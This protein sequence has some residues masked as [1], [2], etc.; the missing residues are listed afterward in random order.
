MTFPFFSENRWMDTCQ[1]D[2][3]ES[4]EKKATFRLEFDDAVTEIIKVRIEWKS[5]PIFTNT[6]PSPWGGETNEHVF[7]N[8]F[9]DQ[10]PSD[11]TMEL[12]GV[13]V[14][15]EYGGPWNTGGGN[16]QVTVEADITQKV[17]DAGIYD[18]HTIEIRTAEPASPRA[19]NFPSQSSHTA[20][21]SH[22]WIEMR[23]HIL[24]VAQAIVP[25]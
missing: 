7:Y 2:S 11:L 23:I 12:N 22:G 1:N 18:V 19:I 15:S 14:S 17:L 21:I 4:P 10:Y 5:L 16:S 13:D 20:L 24:G 8:V 6:F 25:V 9:D 3:S